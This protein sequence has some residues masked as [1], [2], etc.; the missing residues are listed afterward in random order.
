MLV[1]LPRSSCSPHPQFY[2][3]S[4]G[5]LGIQAARVTPLLIPNPEAQRKSPNPQNRLSCRSDQQRG[6]SLG[7][8]L[9]AW[10][11]LGLRAAC[12]GFGFRFRVLGLGFRVRV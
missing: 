4:L 11:V 7:F 2:S 8:G 3:G 1:G 10:G 9:R 5:V 6:V 12:L